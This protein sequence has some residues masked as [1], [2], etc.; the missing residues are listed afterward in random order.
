MK[1]TIAAVVCSGCSS[2]TQWPES[3]M[4]PPVYAADEPH[5]VGHQRLVGVVA[6]EREDRHDQLA[7]RREGFVVDGI[8]GESAKLLESAM[9]G[10][11]RA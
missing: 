11:G 5:D 8:L 1:S 2:I 3:V 10:A 4:R 6:A 9:H 7:L